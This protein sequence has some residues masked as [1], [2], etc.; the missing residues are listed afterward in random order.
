MMKTA[1]ESLIAADTL[2]AWHLVPWT[3][4]NFR[5]NLRF[6]HSVVSQTNMPSLLFVCQPKKATGI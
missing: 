4:T 6:V 2:S 5:H 3:T 1:D